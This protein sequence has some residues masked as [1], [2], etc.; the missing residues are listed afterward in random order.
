[1]S[2]EDEQ[3]T[4]PVAGKGVPEESG[5]ESTRAEEGPTPAGRATRR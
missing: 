4:G 2:T 5:G 3:P 1:M